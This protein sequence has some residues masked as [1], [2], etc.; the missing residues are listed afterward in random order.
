M[1]KGIFAI[2]LI[3]LTLI[4]RSCNRN[5]GLK[6]N[7]ENSAAFD[8]SNNLGYVIENESYKK[9]GVSI[10]YPQINKLG[11]DVKQSEINE[12]IKSEAFTVTDLYEDTD[13]STIEI[14]FKITWKSKNLISIQ[15]Y[16][17][18]FSK[19][20]AYPVDLLYTINI[21]I[22]K[23]SKLR[24]KDYINIDNNFVDKFR[25]YK[26]K[27]PDI[28]QASE[29]AFEYILDTYSVDDLLKY[30]DGADS[31]YNNSAFTFSYFTKDSLGISIE[32]PNAVGDHTEIELKYKD[33]KEN[34]KEDNMV[35]ED[36]L[37]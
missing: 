4:I 26:V 7:N 16:A 23:G 35:W 10:K 15:Y 31:S 11:D 14:D 9:E 37:G 2:L 21:D 28:N 33:I 34:I 6:Q 32:V 36:F 17:S 20:A 22:S 18:G 8:S 29:G 13:V 1:R 5:S 3:A 27:D 12:M 24:L 30:F 25:K 19:G